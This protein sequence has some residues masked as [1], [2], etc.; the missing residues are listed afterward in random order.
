[1]IERQPC[2]YIL[3]SG[4]HGTIYIGVTS[5]LMGRLHQ[6]RGG[7]IPGF[8]SRHQVHRLVHYEVADTMEAAIAR[9]KLIKAWRREWKINLIERDNPFWE[10]R[11]LDLG[12]PPFRQTPSSC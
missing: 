6:H 4:R 7:A 5:D 10:D 12:F 9:E 11:A 3:A 2:V 1:M 8:T